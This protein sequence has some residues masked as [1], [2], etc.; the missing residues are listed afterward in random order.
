MNSVDEMRRKF[1]SE[2]LIRWLLVALLLL[3][4]GIGSALYYPFGSEHVTYQKEDAKTGL[5]FTASCQYVESSFRT[6]VTVRSPGGRVISRNE[7]PFSA[8]ELSDCTREQYYV[9]ADLVPDPAFN[10]LS[11]QFGDKRR[12]AVEVPLLLD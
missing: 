12:S 11:V 10:K 1:M 2:P 8:D 4:G 3:L 6:Y 5:K 7:I 9:V